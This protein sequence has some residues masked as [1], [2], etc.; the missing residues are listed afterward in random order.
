MKVVERHP[1]RTQMTLFS[2]T[3]ATRVFYHKEVKMLTRN[4]GGMDRI[5]R[6]VLGLVLIVVGFFVLP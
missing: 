4:V 2:T 5:V 1:S 3:I 6:I